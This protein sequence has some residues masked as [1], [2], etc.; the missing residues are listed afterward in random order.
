MP[1]LGGVNPT[2]PPVPVGSIGIPLPLG[3]SQGAGAGAGAGAAAT[4]SNEKIQIVNMYVP[5]DE[6]PFGVDIYWMRSSPFG[7]FGESYPV[8]GDAPVAHADFGAAT[9]QF[10]PGDLNGS[11]AWAAFRAGKP[12]TEENKVW[13]FGSGIKDGARTTVVMSSSDTSS[14]PSVK[15]FGVQVSNRD[16]NNPVGGDWTLAPTLG[17]LIVDNSGLD[18]IWGDTSNKL[19]FVRIGDK[20][21]DYWPSSPGQPQAALAGGPTEYQNTAT[22]YGARYRLRARPEPARWVHRQPADKS[23]QRHDPGRRLRLRFRLLDRRH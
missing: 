7:N 3:S 1:T 9:A 15:H 19:M 5:G 13:Y 4:A 16:E 17:T 11:E 14:D 6:P 23:D 18:A 21:G 8:A 22:G 10:D 20:C 12:P 2:L